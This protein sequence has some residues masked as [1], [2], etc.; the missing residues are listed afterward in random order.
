M[1]KVYLDPKWARQQLELYGFQ[2]RVLEPFF[3]ELEKEMA[4]LS[5]KRQY[6]AKQ[7]WEFFGAA[8]TGTGGGL[9]PAA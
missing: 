3:K 6:R 7:L 8:D 9:E 1:A 5:M 4:E 2:D